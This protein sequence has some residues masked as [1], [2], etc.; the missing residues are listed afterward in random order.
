M[1]NIFSITNISGFAE[2]I[3]TGAAESIAENY[4]EDLNDFVTLQQVEKM[5]EDKCLGLDDDGQYMINEE[6]FDSLFEEV[7][8]CIY[9]AG[10]AK[11]AANGAIECAWDDN[12]N[13]MIFWTQ[14]DE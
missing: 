4:R 10:L 7:R 3:R 6:V 9:Q 8:T 14:N 1:T 11:L 5:I 2:T 13:Q 12:M